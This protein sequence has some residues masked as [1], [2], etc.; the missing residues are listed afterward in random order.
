MVYSYK[1]LSGAEDAIYQKISDITIY[2][3]QGK[4]ISIN[5]RKLDALKDLLEA[6]NEKPVL[7]AYWFQH[8]LTRITERLQQQHIS[9]SLLKDADSI[10]RW[11]EG[12][13][14]VVL[15]HS[16]S[17]G[18]GLNLQA[19]GSALIGFGLTW[20]LELYQQTIARLGWRD[21]LRKL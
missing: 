2:D 13:I 12:E 19:A 11:N 1:P 6:A 20:S 18:H 14:Q 4:A 17:A 7:I 5:D 21:R 8:D 10:Y 9:F 15:I 16:A 3:D